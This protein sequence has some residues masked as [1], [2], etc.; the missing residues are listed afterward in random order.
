M[1]AADMQD[2]L[3]QIKESAKSSGKGAKHLELE[4]EN[5]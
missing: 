5:V 1:S 3:L 4:F 2:Y